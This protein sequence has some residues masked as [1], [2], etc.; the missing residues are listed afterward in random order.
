MKWP[1]SW[2]CPYPTPIS[3]SLIHISLIVAAEAGA[4]ALFADGIDLVD[5][6]DAE[7]FFA[8]LLEQ[9]DV[10]KRQFRLHAISRALSIDFATQL[11]INSSSPL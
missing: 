11:L 6:H 4:V 3:L 5:E 7:R 10:Y 8:R 1:R 2:G 9:V